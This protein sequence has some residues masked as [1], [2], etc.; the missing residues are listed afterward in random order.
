MTTTKHLLKG[1]KFNAR[2]STII[3]EAVPLL[4]HLKKQ[5]FVKKIAL[6]CIK[7]NTAS[8]TRIK[9]TRDK[10]AIKLQVYGSAA[11]QL[12]HVFGSLDSI[13]EALTRYAETI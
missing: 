5:P 4:Q 2:H 12:F 1:S 3:D 13:M 6:G 7:P 9:F 10:Y 11:V 8:T